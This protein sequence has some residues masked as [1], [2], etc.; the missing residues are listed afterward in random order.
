M[1]LNLACSQIL[2]AVFPSRSLPS[3]QPPLFLLADHPSLCFQQSLQFF[4]GPEQGLVY[5]TL[6]H[7]S[8]SHVLSWCSGVLRRS[9]SNRREAVR[10]VFTLTKSALTTPKGSR[11]L[12]D[13]SS[14][15][16]KK[17]KSKTLLNKVVRAGLPT[18]GQFWEIL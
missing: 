15:G 16:K 18:A 10:Q 11:D 8:R 1:S 9:R 17:E 7:V 2:L 12:L 6:S 13:S 3:C 4:R 5:R 14:L